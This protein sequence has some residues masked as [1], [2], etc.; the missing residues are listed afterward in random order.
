MVEISRLSQLTNVHLRINHSLSSLFAVAYMHDMEMSKDIQSRASGG[1]KSRAFTT[2]IACL[3]HCM[4]GALCGF[5]SIH[6]A[7]AYVMMGQIGHSVS[8][9][10]T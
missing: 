4:L 7:W 3:G 9:G 8:E 6:D 5:A 2:S 10:C 1:Q